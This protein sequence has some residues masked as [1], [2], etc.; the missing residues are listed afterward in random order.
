MSSFSVSSAFW[1]QA[2]P[3]VGWTMLWF[4]AAG[5]VVLI[6]SAV[7]R[8]ALKRANANLRYSASLAGFAVLAILPIAIAGYLTTSLP[9]DITRSSRPRLN[10][11]TN[12]IELNPNFEPTNHVDSMTSLPRERGERVGDER[13]AEETTNLTNDTNNDFVAPGWDNRAMLNSILNAIVSYLPWLWLVGTPLTFLLLATGLIGAERLRKSCQTLTDGPILAACERVRT[14]LAI[15]RHV[16]IAICHTVSSPLL[17]GV[18][19]PLILLPPAALTGWTTE[20]LEM[21]LLHELAHVR[22]WDNAVNLMQRIVESLLFFHP[23]TWIMSNWVRRDRED[24][25]DA[26]VV[27][28]TA[29]PQAYAELLLTLASYTPGLATSVAMAQH[30]IASRIRRILKI[31]DEPMLI[32][33]KGLTLGV[34]I[35][36]ATVL[37][38]FALPASEAEEASIPRERGETEQVSREAERLGDERSAEETTNLKNDTNKDLATEDTESTEENPLTEYTVV[39]DVEGAVAKFPEL[40]DHLRGVGES[41]FT[42]SGDDQIVVTARRSIHKRVAE[43]LNLHTSKANGELKTL[44]NAQRPIIYAE[45]TDKLS[46]GRYRFSFLVPW[47]RAVDDPVRR[48]TTDALIKSDLLLSRAIKEMDLLEGTQSSVMDYLRKELSVHYSSD[49]HM[50]VALAGAKDSEAAVA[51]Y[52]APIINAYLDEHSARLAKNQHDL[53]TK[54]YKLAGEETTGRYAELV[55]NKQPPASR[56]RERPEN[57][58]D[59][60]AEAAEA[61]K[62]AE[63]PLYPTLEEQRA[64]DFAYK[65]LGVE[66]E[67]LNEAELERAKAMGYS[68]GLKVAG[69]VIFGTEDRVTPLLAGDYLVGLHVWPTESLEQVTEI[70]S[71]DDLDQ[72]SPLKFYVIR[73]SRGGR[74]GGFGGES[75]TPSGTVH[76]VTGRIKVDLDAWAEKEGFKQQRLKQSQPQVDPGPPPSTTMQPRLPVEREKQSPLLYDGKTFDDWRDLWTTELK[77]ERRVECIKALAAFGRAGRGKEASEAIFD[78][79]GQYDFFMIDNR[80]E[81]KLKERVLEELTDYPIHLPERDW[82]PSLKQRLAKEPAKYKW[83]GYG[84]LARLST[85]D[86]DVRQILLGLQEDSERLI[87]SAALVAILNS[88]EIFTDAEKKQQVQA[89]LQKDAIAGLNAL[90]GYNMKFIEEDQLLSFLL[91]SDPE[92]QAAARGT[93]SN[94]NDADTGSHLANALL[95]ILNDSKREQDQ[96]ATVRALAALRNYAEQAEP[97]LNSII[98]STRDEEMVIAA[99]FARQQVFIGPGAWYVDVSDDSKN[100][101]NKSK[102]WKALTN[103][104]DD[105]ILNEK[106][107][108]E[109]RNVLGVEPNPYGFGGSG[110]GMG[111]GGGGMF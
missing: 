29:K 17:I 1:Q 12:F 7:L 46:D 30:P 22:R 93:T 73:T 54:D 10:E 13:A 97:V 26:I 15:A 4:L 104:Q 44:N 77:T 11:T 59:L 82:L 60:N 105:S 94:I 98:D 19:K 92:I 75:P 79:A 16:G 5:T 39:Y 57:T 42:S 35:V 27:R 65:L 48:A 95:A 70:L 28:Q 31:E 72:L 111:G 76:L 23:A 63:S 106:L 45:Q 107:R 71:R 6:V 109:Y 85:T 83:L 55:T 110:G 18:V 69:P 47:V 58:A 33:R 88:R 91:H 61:A 51:K 100:I 38:A 25:C 52:A 78:V 3:L 40:I 8:I 14:Q 9:R 108:A 102:K 84:L 50:F 53:A 43:Y 24:C 89:T 81:G 41:K 34:G 62:V 2:W 90:G 36:I 32:S 49:G 66:L 80:A 96:L 101:V 37:L 86:A 103:S 21:V 20:E 87:R 64:T 99:I 67:K 56:K 74:G 68:G